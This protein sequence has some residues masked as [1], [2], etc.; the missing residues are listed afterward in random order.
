MFR[1]SA[2]RPLFRHARHINAAPIRQ[3]STA[4]A[5]FVDPTITHG[6]Q[7]R[8]L[9]ISIGSPSS[10]YVIVEPGVAS[11]LVGK[12][13]AQGEKA[14]VPLLFL[15]KTRHFAQSKFIDPYTRL[16]CPI[17]ISKHTI[18]DDDD[19]C[20]KLYL[21]QDLASKVSNGI[22]SPA[23]LFRYGVNSTLTIQGSKDGTFLSVCQSIPLLD[24]TR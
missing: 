5:T 24:D 11:K 20:P 4:R 23:I 17:L 12:Q 16:L 22:S 2:Y 10:S 15:H 3:L 7:K 1:L 18:I 9:N 6:P 14:E 13:F 21:D 8:V 19:A